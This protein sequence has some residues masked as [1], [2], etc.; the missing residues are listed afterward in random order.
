MPKVNLTPHIYDDLPR[1][2]RTLAAVRG[3]RTDAAI[4]EKIGLTR[5][6]LSY[7]L[8]NPQSIDAQMIDRLCRVLRVKPSQ[9]WEPAIVTEKC[10][11]LEVR[12]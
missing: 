6:A 2:I 4:A 5:S 10:K 1:N 11:P 7:R 8:R 9:L 3:Y 12:A